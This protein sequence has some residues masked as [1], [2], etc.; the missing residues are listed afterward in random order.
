MYASLL[1]LA[2]GTFLKRVNGVTIVLVCISLI[3]VWLTAK[4]EERENLER[5]GAA[6][7][8]RYK[9]ETKMFIP[10]LW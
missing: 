3:S 5:F 9:S 4:A 6:D 1:F 7:Y 10:Y 2:V 8:E